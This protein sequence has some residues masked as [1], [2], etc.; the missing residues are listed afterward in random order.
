MKASKMQKVVEKLTLVLACWLLI[1]SLIFAVVA[2]R[3]PFYIVNQ[4][5]YRYDYDRLA[6]ISIF[7]FLVYLPSLVLWLISTIS[8]SFIAK[9]VGQAKTAVALALGPVL[10][11]GMIPVYLALSFSL[12]FGLA[13]SFSSICITIILSIILFRRGERRDA[14]RE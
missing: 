1:L 3:I 4:Y 14:L 13:I 10:V 11:I 5:G 12:Q 7:L 9:R 6:G 2:V 8:A